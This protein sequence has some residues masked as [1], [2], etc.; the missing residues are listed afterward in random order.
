MV[1]ERPGGSGGEKDGARDWRGQWGEG[2]WHFADPP[3][4]G[5]RAQGRGEGQGEKAAEGAENAAGLRA[6][7]EEIDHRW[8][9]KEGFEPDSGR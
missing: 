5:G 8:V 2:G 4:A 3:A 7:C 6:G 1:T 9:G